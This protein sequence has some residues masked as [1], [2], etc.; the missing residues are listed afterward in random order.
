MG[1]ILST[2][3]MGKILRT[4]IT[5]KIISL[6]KNQTS[7]NN[8]HN[9]Q[10]AKNQLFSND[11]CNSNDD[12][13]TATENADNVLYEIPT[14]KKNASS[15]HK[16]FKREIVTQQSKA[17]KVFNYKI[18]QI[19]ITEKEPIKTTEEINE[20][21][22]TFARAIKKACSELRSYHDNKE[23]SMK[24]E[25]R[26]LQTIVEHLKKESIDLKSK[27]KITKLPESTKTQLNIKKLNE[28]IQ[29]HN[30]GIK[31]INLQLKNHDHNYIRNTLERID[32]NLK[33]HEEKIKKQ[34]NSDK[35]VDQKT[36]EIFN[37]L[38]SFQDNGNPWL[39]VGIMG[40]I[41]MTRK[42]QQMNCK[43]NNHEA[44]SL[45]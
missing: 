39:T 6:K 35:A 34:L 31:S 36:K 16:D 17:Q 12:N 45:N 24:L 22:E 43:E 7:Y 38:E 27:A 13:K 1:K 20:L 10:H 3:E 41:I 30:E 21:K 40:K 18:E 11:T 23:E 32:N 19:K 8:E 14:Y 29:E 44:K 15:K 26:N 25:I 5:S 28:S 33:E 37:T 2:F 9:E 4:R 42:P